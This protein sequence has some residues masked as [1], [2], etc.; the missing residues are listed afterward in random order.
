MASFSNFESKN[1]KHEKD[2]YDIYESSFESPIKASEY[3]SS[4]ITKN[5]SQFAELCSFLRWMPDIF[6]DMYK[7][8]V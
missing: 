5:I 2:R 8:V 4:I 3:N 1:K 6:W 7:P